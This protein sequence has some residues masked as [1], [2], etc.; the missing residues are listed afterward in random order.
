MPT[1]TDAPMSGVN[2]KVA[3]E[4]SIVVA[5]VAMIA[6]VS[7]LSWTHMTTVATVHDRS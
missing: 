5:Q 4:L 1:S 6:K 3:V 7:L 2:V